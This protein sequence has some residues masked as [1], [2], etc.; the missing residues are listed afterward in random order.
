MDFFRRVV[1]LITYYM[2]CF[3][4][5]KRLKNH[6]RTK[7]DSIQQIIGQLEGN[8]IT[9]APGFTGEISKSAIK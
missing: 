6:I 3:F 5:Y 1:L 9:F 7:N 4:I 2:R 8:V